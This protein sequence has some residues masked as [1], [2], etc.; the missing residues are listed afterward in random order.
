MIV[1]LACFKFL[2][3]WKSIKK[4]VRELNRSSLKTVAKFLFVFPCSAGLFFK[5]KALA[6]P[7]AAA[8]L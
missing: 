7:A 4:T 2:V 8:Y 3:Q 6:F 5:V 1:I